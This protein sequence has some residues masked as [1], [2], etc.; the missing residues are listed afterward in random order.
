MDLPEQ[1]AEGLLKLLETQ[2]LDS[3]FAE[4]LVDFLLAQQTG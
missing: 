2:K 3:A 1:S 4:S